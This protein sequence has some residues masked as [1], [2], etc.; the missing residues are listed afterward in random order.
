MSPTTIELPHVA[1]VSH[2][3]HDIG[4]I[5]VHVAEAGSGPPLVLL[6]GWPQHWYCWRRVVPLLAVDHRVIMPDLRGFGWTDAPRTGYEKEQLATDLFRLLD[7]MELDRVGLVGH[8]WGGWVGFL[9]SLRDPERFRAFVALGIVHPFQKPSLGKVA[10]AWRG[11]Y[12][13]ALAAPVVSRLAL[14][15]SPRLVDTMVR[16]GLRGGGDAPGIGNPAAEDPPRYGAVLQQ[17]ERARAS[18]QMYRTFLAREVPN[19]GRYNGQRLHVPTRLLVGA[20]DPI[21]S[22][23][24]LDGWQ[25]NADD[26]TVEVV[27]DAG[28]FLPEEVPL[29]VAQLV[30]STMDGSASRTGG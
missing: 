6:H 5:T 2:A 29:R 26:M 16:L 4:G 24:L 28:H 12:Q 20:Q 14:Q 30:R 21:S 18:V 22:P 15:S 19:L 3:R 9:A 13:V 23:S 7:V 1:G 10:Q 27:P 17:P 11:A 8:D 25:D